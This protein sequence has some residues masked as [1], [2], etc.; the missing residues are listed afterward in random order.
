MIAS[1]RFL[2]IA[3]AVPAMKR[4]FLRLLFLSSLMGCLSLGPVSLGQGGGQ[5]WRLPFLSR[6]IAQPA[7]AQTTDAAQ[8][9]QQGVD[10]YQAGDLT[11]ALTAWKA[12]LTQYEQSRDR[13]NAAIVVENLARTYQSLGQSEAAIGY[14]RRGIKLHQ[15]LGNL[16]EVGRLLVE[17]AQAHSRSGQAQQA[18]ELLCH[19]GTDGQ[20]RPDSALQ[21]A[22]TAKATDLEAAALGSLGDAYRLRGDINPAIE[23]LQASLKLAQTIANPA[24]QISALN[25]LGNAYSSRAQRSYRRA[26]SAQQSGDQQQA[27][28]LQKNRR[29]RRCSGIGL[30]SPK[31]GTGTIASQPFCPD[32]IA[33]ECDS[34]PLPHQ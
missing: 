16:P 22:R 19:P 34:A 14:W 30:S 21:I 23:S 3:V 12:A 6:A 33:P 9:V 10:R 8:L 25:S 15:Q 7:I 31:L 26:S 4:R 29:N 28:I 18:I 24:Y 11:G 17:Q 13:P 32:A 2:P 5:P 1:N 20:C 27:T